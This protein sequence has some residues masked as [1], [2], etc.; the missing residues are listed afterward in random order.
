[1]SASILTVRDLTKRFGGIVAVEDLTFSAEREQVTSLIG[2]NGAGKTTV[3]NL[4]TGLYAPTKGDIRFDGHGRSVSITDTIFDP[5][6]ATI[7]SLASVGLGLI[8]LAIPSARRLLYFRPRTPDS[9]CSV[10]I[11]RTFQNIRLFNAVSVLDNVKVGL[12]ARIRS[13]IVD[14]ALRTRRHRREER[15][16]AH[17]AAKYLDFVGLLHRAHDAASE[18]AYGEQRRLEIARALATNP[19]LLLL[20]EPAAGMNPTETNELIRLIARIRD[21]G[22]TVLLIEHDMKVVMGIS[23]RVIVLDHG[24]KIAEGSPSDVRRDPEVIRA[25][26]GVSDESELS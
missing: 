17:A 6:H 1:L 4:V 20:D 12:H 18:L 15:D 19:Q 11:A 22:V 23:D 24:R 26:L 10:G 5:F 8:P 21:A 25:Y 2:P 16:V 13:H 7:V 14:A 3:F 9:I